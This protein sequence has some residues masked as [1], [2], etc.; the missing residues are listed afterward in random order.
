MPRVAFTQTLHRH[1]SA[2]PSQ[3]AGSTVRQ[4]LE[5][6]F[7]ENPRLRGYVVTSIKETMA[8]IDQS[9]PS[10]QRTSIAPP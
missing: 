5:V 10:L 1:L 4:A 3:V 9:S 2:P 7:R 8:L 6:V